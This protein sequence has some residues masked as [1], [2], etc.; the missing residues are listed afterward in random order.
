MPKPD[1]GT[2]HGGRVNKPKI[3]IV[4]D[5]GIIARDIRQQLGEL[6]YEAVGDT[7]TGEDAIVLTGQLKPD[8]VLMDIHLAGKLD[9]IEAA[10]AIRRQ[11][12]TPVVFLTA[13]AGAE[14]LER[15]KVTEPFGYI[16]KPFDERYLHTIIEM[17]LYKH[18]AETQLRRSY[19]E[20]ATILRTALDAFFIADWQGRLLDVNESSCAM[21]GYSRAELL[22]MSLTDLDASPDTAKTAVILGMKQRGTARFERSQ[23]HKDGRAIQVEMSL[24]YLPHEGGRIFC[25]ARDIT[26]RKAAEDAL[27]RL[28]E[29]LE[30]RVSMRTQDLEEARKEAEKANQAKANFLATMTHELRTPLNGVIGTLDVLRQTTLEGHQT[31]MLDLMN[32]SALSLLAI[33]DDILDFSKIEAGRLG[34]EVRPF[35]PQA[36]VEKACSVLAPM[37]EHSGVELTLFTDPKLPP[38]VLGDAVRLKQV[39]LN[40]ANNA[41]KFSSGQERPSRVSVRVVLA[42]QA[43][44]EATLEFEVKDNGIGMGAETRSGL[45]KSFTQGDPSITRRFGGTGLGLAISRNLVDLMGGTIHATSEPGQGSTFRVRVPFAL[46]GDAPSALP[47]A[48]ELAGLS[49]LMVGEPDELRGDLA[50]YLEAAGA[51]VDHVPDLQSARKYSD[52]H[53]IGLLV[54]VVDVGGE[55]LSPEALRAA[56]GEKPGKEIRFVLVSRGR[57]RKTRPLAR[58]VF[59]VDANLMKQ[60]AFLSA[61]ASAAGR[62]EVESATTP[63]TIRRA[64][65]KPPSRAEAIKAGRLLLVAEDN[66]INQKVILR[67]LGL[68]GYAADVCAGG[69]EALERWHTGDY[70]LLLADLH[71]PGMDG[72]QLTAAIRV[73]EGAEQHAV[74]IAL[75]AD[76]LKGGAQQ[77]RDAGMDD[78]LC[79]PARL[80]EVKAMIEKW[81]PTDRPAPAS[82]PPSPITAPAGSAG[83]PVDIAVLEELVGR[84]PDVI[85]EFLRAFWISTA[86]TASELHAA[87]Q[88]KDAA[89]IAGLA[90]KLKAPARS[91]GAVRLAGLCDDLQRAAEASDFAAVEKILP[92]FEAEKANVE[93]YLRQA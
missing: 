26:E 74:I 92:Q 87:G 89:L 11:Y 49:C 21:L 1:L 57:Q 60:D 16:I 50:A 31:E 45:F 66:E 72:Y 77:C 24:N 27:M 7:P 10:Q 65:P 71:M 20:Q 88:G 41:V 18:R 19:D 59:A 73:Q 42:A 68:L 64:P 69:R 86:K 9:G 48:S 32:E 55:S 83:S 82:A 70:S 33:V 76:V 22:Q 79:K 39:L 67:Q 54:W 12:G 58:G 35:S 63:I 52:A 61:V 38:I 30:V 3:L 84:D 47:E 81:L 6:G 17:A 28:N 43:R 85:H 93:E 51:A 46:P 15:A 62:V 78:Y 90:H 25:F 91:V 5:E 14:T 80:S 23:R 56:S 37:V 53:P 44:D 36:V 8:L 40:L 4:E 34:L 2:C 29:E 13:F 75:T